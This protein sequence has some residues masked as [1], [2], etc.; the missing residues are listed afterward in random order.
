MAERKTV[1]FETPHDNSDGEVEPDP[2]VQE[3]QDHDADG[4][5]GDRETAPDPQDDA[6]QSTTSQPVSPSAGKKKKKRKKTR[7]ASKRGL[8][9]PSGFEE[10]HADTPLTPEEYAEDLELYDP[11]FPFAERIITAIQRYERRRKLDSEM[12]D[13]FFKYLS[14]GG[15]DTSP[16]MFQGGY[17][18]AELEDMDKNQLAAAMARTSINADKDNTDGENAAFAVDFEG[19]MKGF[20]SRRA[21]YYFGFEVKEQV[22]I[23]TRVLRNFLN[24]LLHHNVCPEYK[25]DILAAREVCTVAYH[26]LWA[27][28]EAQRWLPGDFNIA[29]STLFGGSYGKNY[30]GVAKWMDETVDSSSFVGMTAEVARVVVKFAVAGAGSEEVYQKWHNLTLQNDIRVVEVHERAGF[31]V[32][33]IE[34]CDEETK[35]FYTQHSPNYTP[36]GKI[37]AKPWKN[38]EAPPE[39]LTEEECEQLETSKNTANGWEMIEGTLWE[40]PYEFFVEEV[41]LE[42][43]FVGMKVEATLH[44]LN[45]GIWFFDDVLRTFCS[46]DTYLCN[47]MM[48]GW[49]PPRAIPFVPQPKQEQAEGGLELGL[50][51]PPTPEGL[52]PRSHVG[53]STVANAE[54]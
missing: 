53:I 20:L 50:P 2:V 31:E 22:E 24:Y 3:N 25:E 52:G 11:A 19:V 4:E 18:K 36:V 43:M 44:R 48:V 26:E 40:E 54:R 10:Y 45:C 37:F 15:I 13:I 30:D 27:C 8:N 39:D 9:A 41:V 47:E 29:C 33:R 1:S 5:N 12:R 46:F 14:Y 38:P 16:N 42:H 17:G 32:R 49:K 34:H 28:A 51:E 23:I 7:P 21:P 35:A 6:S